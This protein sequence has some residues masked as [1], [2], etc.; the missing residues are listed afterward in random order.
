MMRK[1]ASLALALGLVFGVVGAANGAVVRGRWSYGSTWMQ[2]YDPTPLGLWKVVTYYD[3]R[4]NGITVQTTAPMRCVVFY[5]IAYTIT[6][7][8]CNLDTVYV[9]IAFRHPG[10]VH[11]TGIWAKRWRVT[12][13]WQTCFFSICADHGHSL[14]MDAYGYTTEKR[15]W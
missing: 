12:T 5:A 13:H 11:P 7:T 2:S 8:Y 9:W 3:L 15:A 10:A 1:I 4:L 6:I 14:T